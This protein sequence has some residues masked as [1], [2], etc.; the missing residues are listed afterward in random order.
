MKI[1][2]ESIDLIITSPPYWNKKDYDHKE[3]IG[4]N[5]TYEEYIDDLNKIWEQCN[6]TLIPGRKICIIIGDVYLSSKEYGRY[7]VISIKTDIINYCEKNLNLDYYGAIIWQKICKTKPSGGVNG[8]FMGSY[9][10]P[11]NGILTL[12]YEYI[13]IFKKIGSIKKVPREIKQISKIPKKS[14]EKYFNGH[15]SIPGDK[16]INHPA[17]FPLEVPKRLIK[18]YSFVGDTILDPFAG[19]GTT[20]LASRILKRN[21][22]GIEIN[23]EKYWPVIDKKI[24]F[25]QSG[26]FHDCKFIIKNPEV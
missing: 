23:K 24:G 2:S 16:D 11:P 18:M 6:R 17:T 9:P 26:L 12:D 19:S 13:L 15:W 8:R 25:H 5:Q 3:Q 22:I 1:P 21:S 4:F 7:K 20:N 14:W 10:Y